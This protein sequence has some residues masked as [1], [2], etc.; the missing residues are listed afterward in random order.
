MKILWIVPGL[1]MAVAQF[2][3]SILMVRLHGIPAKLLLLAGKLLLW[4]LF[5]VLLVRISATALLFGGIAALT[6]YTLLAVFWMLRHMR[7]NQKEK[8]H[9]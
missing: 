1:L 4:G 9:A 6:G 5:F 7:D 2:L 8:E 3:L